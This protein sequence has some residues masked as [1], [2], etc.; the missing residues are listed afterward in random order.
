MYF[1][2]R[3]VLYRKQLLCRRWR[4]CKRWHHDILLLWWWPPGVAVA[5]SGQVAQA[6]AAD[7]LCLKPHKHLRMLSLSHRE[8]I[9]LPLQQPEVLSDSQCPL[10][11]SQGP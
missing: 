3:Q 11:Y 7:A 10:L 5:C 6:V 8:R 1:R 4:W 2:G 9:G